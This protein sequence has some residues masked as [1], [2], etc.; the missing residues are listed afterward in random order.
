MYGTS[1]VHGVEL[2]E[3]FVKND[4]FGIILVEKDGICSP[5]FSDGAILTQGEFIPKFF[6]RFGASFALLSMKGSFM[7]FS[8]KT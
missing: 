6:E 1:G 3:L 5:Q 4:R 8:Y 7:A 2:L